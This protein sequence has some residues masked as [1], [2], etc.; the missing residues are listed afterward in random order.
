MA[1]A[2]SEIVF[3]P[4]PGF[5]EW[6][7]YA[8]RE[9]HLYRK[10]EKKGEIIFREIGTKNSKY[11]RFTVRNNGTILR[12]YN[13]VLIARTFIDNPDNKPYVDHIN[14]DRS[15]N[16]VDNL[17]WVT[18]QE[19]SFNRKKQEG[20]SSEYIGVSLDQSCDKWLVCIYLNGKNIHVGRFDK[21]NEIEAAKAH[22]K[23]A[24][25]YHGEY[26]HLNFPDDE[27]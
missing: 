5:E 21:K 6:S 14:R 11:M 13:H 24:R 22:D 4:V 3:V 17:R 18:S 7:L 8:T 27:E 2:K 12:G 16:R 20:T 9:G 1:E 25:K 23:A 19:N 15:D 26:A 10:K